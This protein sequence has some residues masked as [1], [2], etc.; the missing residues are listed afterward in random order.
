M[1][2]HIPYDVALE[3][4]S[5]TTTSFASIGKQQCNYESLGRSHRC[6]RKRVRVEVLIRSRSVL[7]KQEWPT[8]AE[9]NGAFPQYYN[10]LGVAHD[11]TR[12]DISQAYK[13]LALSE[14]P[15][16]NSSTPEAN[17][18][19]AKVN[20][21]RDKLTSGELRNDYDRQAVKEAQKRVGS[22]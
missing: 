19:F 8:F 2:S 14:H 17:E 13:A 16:K 3:E 20:Q 15:A 5:H 9:T 6:V 18:K 12:L 1:L 10:I 4:R 7:A 22:G 11:A 21:A